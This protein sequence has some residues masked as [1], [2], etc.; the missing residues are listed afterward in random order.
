MIPYPLLPGQLETFPD[1]RPVDTRPCQTCA[2]FGI[3][4]TPTLP[5]TAPCIM[6]GGTGWREFYMIG[7]VNMEYTDDHK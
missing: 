6:C 3:I 2:G 4:D 5:Y 1:P 7:P